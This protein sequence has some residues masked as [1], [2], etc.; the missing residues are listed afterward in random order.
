LVSIHAGLGLLTFQMENLI[1]IFFPLSC[2][3]F[4]YICMFII[5]PRSKIQGVFR[6]FLSLYYCIRV[7]EWHGG[8]KRW[9]IFY[10]V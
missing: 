3:Q 10:E 6:T 5:K 7:V 9:F 8:P 4:L 1:S 2:M